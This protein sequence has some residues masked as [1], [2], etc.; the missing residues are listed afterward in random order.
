VRFGGVNIRSNEALR[1]KWHIKSFP[2]VAS[3][4]KGQ[5]VEDMR[6]LAGAQV[7]YY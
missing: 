5:K 2:W 4:F 3:F 1:D 7:L 6:G